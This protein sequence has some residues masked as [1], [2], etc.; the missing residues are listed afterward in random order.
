MKIQAEI[1][2]KYQ[3]ENQA[4]IALNSMQPD[5]IGFINSY[6][7]HEYVIC[8]INSDSLRTVLATADDLLFGEMMVEKLLSLVEGDNK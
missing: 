7:D 5:N 4:E 1:I 8:N 6:K 3:N 2:F